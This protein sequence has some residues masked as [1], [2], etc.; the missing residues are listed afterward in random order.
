MKISTKNFWIKLFIVIFACALFSICFSLALAKNHKEKAYAQDELEYNEIIIIESQEN[1]KYLLSNYDSELSIEKNQPLADVIADIINTCKENGTKGVNIS[2]RITNNVENNI[3]LNLDS[4]QTLCLSGEF[5][6]QCQEETIFILESGKLTL[7]GLVLKASTQA[8][9]VERGALLELKSGSIS[10]SNAA[11]SD[12]AVAIKG[13]AV[14]GQGII[15]YNQDAQSFGYALSVESES[16]VTVENGA[17]ITGNS[18]ILVDGTVVIDNDSG[19]IKANRSLGTSAGYALTLTSSGKGQI[20]GGK[21][22]TYNK[23]AIFIAGNSNCTL[24]ITGGEFIGGIK[25]ARAQSAPSLT[26]FNKTYQSSPHRDVDIN[27]N[28]NI[29]KVDE[30]NLSDIVISTLPVDLID[31]YRTIGWQW[32]IDENIE[33]SNDLILTAQDFDENTTIRP[34]ESNLYTIKFYDSQEFVDEINGIEYNTNFDL[35]VK[36]EQKLGYEFVGWSLT[37]GGDTLSTI[38]VDRD[39]TLYAGYNLQPASIENLD[40]IV[41]I[42]NK[43]TSYTLTASVMHYFDKEATYLYAWQ[44]QVDER[45]E[46]IG[47]NK[48]SL[49]V[50]NCLHSGVYRVEVTTRYQG[51]SAVSYSQPIVVEISKANYE[52]ITHNILSS[53]YSSEQRLSDFELEPFFTW[54]EPS[55][56]PTCDITEYRAVYNADP[57]NY[58][59]YELYITLILSKAKYSSVNAHKIFQGSNYI[60]NPQNTLSNFELDNNYYW[61]DPSEVPV[62]NK[63]EYKAYYNA[64][65]INYEDKELYIQVFLLKAE[66]PQEKMQVA[67]ERKFSQSQDN[68]LLYLQNNMPEN[69]EG[70]F[71]NKEQIEMMNIF[72]IPSQSPFIFENCIYNLDPDNYHDLIGV[73]IIVNVDKAD[74]ENIEYNEILYGA[75][76]KDQTLKDFELTQFFRWKDQDIVPTCY[77]TEYRAVYSDPDK[78]DFYHDYE[79]DVKI[80]LEK[81]NYEID[82]VKMLSLSGTYNPKMTLRSYALEEFYTWKN[83]DIVPTCDVKE[84]KAIYN[85]DTVNYNDFECDIIIELR[86]AQLDLSG[87]TLPDKAVVYDGKEHYLEYLGT[88]PDGVEFV[89]Y[90]N[91]DGHITSGVYTISIILKQLDEI[92]YRRINNNIKGVLTIQ[93]A[94][95][96]IIADERQSFVYDGKVKSITAKVANSEQS[97]NYSIANSFRAIGEYTIILSTDEGI[98]YLAAQKEVKVFINPIEKIIGSPKAK[99][100]AKQGPISFGTIRNKSGIDSDLEVVMEYKNAKNYDFMPKKRQVALLEVNLLLDG[101]SYDYKGEEYKITALLPNKLKGKKITASYVDNNGNLMPVNTAINGNCLIIYSEN[102]GYFVISQKNNTLDWWAWLLISVA[103]TSALSVGI[104]WLYKYKDK[105]FATN[106]TKDAIIE[107]ERKSTSSGKEKENNE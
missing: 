3:V 29:I 103:I 102:L 56:I 86:K 44:K 51:V 40:D 82:D 89:K 25:I 66:Y 72:L 22:E 19:I 11:D 15:N 104:Y 96:I 69:Y 45:F 9:S 50:N 47:E 68:S 73:T 62:C 13:S 63:T 76:H 30:T 106:K 91:N 93:K 67:I 105:I 33:S 53:V 24:K 5:I 46:Y 95:S 94:P 98:N 71:F 77:K 97:L 14:I 74:Y 75:Y 2:F 32:E 107:S 55:E 49:E 31:G 58:N 52:D 35:S 7:Q 6:S 92:N 99:T 18:G 16:F 43:D 100:T 42:Y 87:I 27:A 90:D 26:I 8:I 61:K 23:S 48:A 38:I 28:S 101:K 12:S 39:Y 85:G 65:A 79:L 10:V 17:Q 81:G 78:A 80:I 1:G 59:D 88:L 54:Q 4:D 21:F 37:D 20:K 84:Y 70:Y 83:A 34:L 36:S 64:D 41:C 57:D 60:Y